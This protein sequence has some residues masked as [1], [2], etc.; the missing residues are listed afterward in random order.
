MAGLDGIANKID[1]GMP[2]EKDLYELPPEEAAEIKQLPGSL[3]E[4]LDALEVDQ[5]FLMKGDVFTPDLISTWIDYK[6]KNEVDAIRLRP[7][8][9]EFAL[10]FDI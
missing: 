10:Y 1:P 5:A 7:H 4:V 8:P 6:R 9:W 3:E 2:M